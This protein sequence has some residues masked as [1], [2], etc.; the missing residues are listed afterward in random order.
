VAGQCDVDFLQPV[1]VRV[2]HV[3][4][5]HYAEYIVEPVGTGLRSTGTGAWDTGVMP[6]SLTSLVSRC[7]PEMDGY[8][9]AEVKE[10]DWWKTV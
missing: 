8:E 5:Q 7:M 2:G 10:S 3:G 6:S 1:F 9:F 4:A